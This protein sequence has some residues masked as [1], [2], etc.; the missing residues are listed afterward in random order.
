MRSVQAPRASQHASRQPPATASTSRLPAAAAG[1]HPQAHERQRGRAR[2]A[3][4][5]R[6]LN[7]FRDLAL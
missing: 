5:L 1:A 4:P 3:L 2:G 7:Q 6:G